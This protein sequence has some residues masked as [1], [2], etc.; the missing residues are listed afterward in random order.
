MEH[1]DPQRL[2]GAWQLERWEIA[3]EDGTASLPFGPDAEGLL[4]YTADGWMSASIMTA[5]RARLSRANPRAAPAAERATAFDGYFSYCGRW[6]IVGQGVQHD[7]SIALNPGMVGTPQV[8]AV[9]L[10]D[11]TLTLSAEEAGPG[12]I[13]VHRLRW[14]RPGLRPGKDLASTEESATP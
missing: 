6:R 10:R 14:R 1:I 7:V 8:R 5:G 3:Y 2:V 11:R 13:R 9:L 12:G 4:L